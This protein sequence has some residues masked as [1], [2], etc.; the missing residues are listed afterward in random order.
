MTKDQTPANEQY[1][2]V[3]YH[4]VCHRDEH[5]V[6]MGM[7]PIYEFDGHG[8]D[9]WYNAAE[10]AFYAGDAWFCDLAEVTFWTPGHEPM[11]GLAYK[12]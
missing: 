1:C 9:L 6:K 2:N 8:E 11:I 7:D 4:R 10:K 12:M 5:L 3:K